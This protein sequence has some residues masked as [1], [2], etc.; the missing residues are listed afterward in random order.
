EEKGLIKSSRAFD[1]YVRLE[2]VENNLLAG[3][4]TL[5]KNM[6][7][8]EIVGH[9]QKGQSDTFRLT[10]YPGAVLR[11][12]TDTPDDKKTDVVTVLKNAGYSDAAS[13][14]G[15]KKQYVHPLF[16]SKPAS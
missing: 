5:G 16:A 4:Y 2:S 7:V 6:T 1:W 3:K 14:A 10:F 15:L 12:T 11:D 13:D 8:E 9:L